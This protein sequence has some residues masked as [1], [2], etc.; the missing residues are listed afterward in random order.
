MSETKTWHVAPSGD[1][2][3]SLRKEGAV[4]VSGKFETK[5]GAVDSVRVIG[6]KDGAVVYVH[7]RDGT[8]KEKNTYGSSA[9]YPAKR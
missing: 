8:I 4:R 1:G 7:G 5:S 2:A 3:W 9:A 6:K